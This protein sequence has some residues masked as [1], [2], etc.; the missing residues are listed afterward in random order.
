[1]SALKR[2]WWR[3]S[4]GLVLMGDLRPKFMTQAP[5]DF[6]RWH[7]TLSPTGFVLRHSKVCNLAFLDKDWFQISSLSVLPF[8]VKHGTLPMDFLPPSCDGKTGIWITAGPYD[9]TQCKG[10]NSEHNWAECSGALGFKLRPYL[11]FVNFFTLTLL[12][13]KSLVIFLSFLFR[14]LR[15]STR[16]LTSQKMKR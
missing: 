11:I 16:P 8:A 6:A 3:L 2:W 10:E 13:P 4:V 7:N 9:D 1:M 15:T 5:P 14:T 12:H